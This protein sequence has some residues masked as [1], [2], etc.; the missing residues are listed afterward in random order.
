MVHSARLDQWFP[1]KYKRETRCSLS[2]YNQLWDIIFDSGHVTPGHTTYIDFSM[3]GSISGHTAKGKW[4][5]EQNNLGYS[6]LYNITIIIIIIIIIIIM[7][8]DL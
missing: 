4:V 2:I 6:A 3:D 7:Q 8:M 5:G 1:I